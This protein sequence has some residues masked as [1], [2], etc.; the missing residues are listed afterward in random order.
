VVQLFDENAYF[1]TQAFGGALGCLLSHVSIYKNA[2]DEGFET[3]WICEDDIEFKQDAEKVSLLL[4]QLS[5]LDPEWDVLYTDSCLRSKDLQQ[6]RPGQSFYT[7]VY[8]PINNDL[9][10]IHGR[11]NTHSM[12]FSKKGL[13]KVYQYFTHGLLWGPIDIDIHY[14]PD[15]REYCARRNLVTSIY[16][17]FLAAFDGS[18]DTQFL[19]HLNQDP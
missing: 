11:F 18:S 12:I 7:Q 4:K 5:E 19:S 16:D 17:S 9:V 2:L 6:P 8:S 15:I 10:K 14:T 1:R 13:K 3:I